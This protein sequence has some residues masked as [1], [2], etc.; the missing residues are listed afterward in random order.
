MLLLKQIPHTRVEVRVLAARTDLA[1]GIL[2]VLAGEGWLI[3][4]CAGFYDFA[5]ARAI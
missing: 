3:L 4:R 5:E 2:R 1:P